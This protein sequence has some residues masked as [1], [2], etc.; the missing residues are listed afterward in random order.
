MQKWELKRKKEKR[1]G[2]EREV[3]KE[4]G[5]GLSASTGLR[6]LAL[7][8]GC[9]SARIHSDK[10]LAICLVS[11][12]ESNTEDIKT[13]GMTYLPPQKQHSEF[14]LF[15]ANCECFRV[16]ESKSF[17]SRSRWP[18]CGREQRLIIPFCEPWV[19]L[20][21]STDHIH[22][23]IYLES[24]LSQQNFSPYFFPSSWSVLFVCLRHWFP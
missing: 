15:L 23:H 3:E 7:E 4:E 17:V 20:W 2:R 19:L 8:A 9:S 12:A 16:D 14:F 1:R 24:S 10:E 13:W 5:P 22:F 21:L 11:S 6:R 18:H